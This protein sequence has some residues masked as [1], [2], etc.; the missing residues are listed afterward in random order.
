MNK[1]V[2]SRNIDDLH[3]A[4]ARGCNEFIRRMNQSGFSNVGISATYRDTVHQNWLFAQGRTRP[5]NIVT[6]AAGGQSIH[7]FRLA[8]DFFR[9]IPGEAFNDSTQEERRFWDTAGKIWTEMGGVWGGS[10]SRFVDRPH[11]EYTGGLSLRE[12]QKGKILPHDHKM[13]WEDEGMIFKTVNDMPS[14]AQETIQALIDAGVLS[15][16]GKDPDT[17]DIILDMPET[18]MRTLV[19][20]RNMFRVQEKLI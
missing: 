14:W 7:N 20:T 4:V 11:C 2:N 8:F 19:V 13:L 6:N 5:G 10:W 15:G 17:G 9:N 1:G 3:P 12:L 18:M 16:T